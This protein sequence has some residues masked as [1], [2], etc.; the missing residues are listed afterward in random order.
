MV[1]FKE[2]STR[3]KNLK[4]KREDGILVSTMVADYGAA[5]MSLYGSRNIQKLDSG[6]FVGFHAASR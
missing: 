5:G 2:Y 3:Y 6:I 1:M 4:M